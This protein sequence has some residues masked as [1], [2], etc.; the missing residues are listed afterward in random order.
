MT[1]RAF[2]A[3]AVAATLRL[4]LPPHPPARATLAGA[5]SPAT[6]RWAVARAE[7]APGMI[8][9]PTGFE[10]A[11]R[12][13]YPEQSPE[14]RAVL[15]LRQLK[16][17]GRLP[18]RLVVMVWSGAEGHWTRPFP[19]GAPSVQQLLEQETGVRLEIEPV[20]Y[21]QSLTRALQDTLNGERH[22]DIYAFSL[23]AIGTLVESGALLNLDP[24]VDRYKPEWENQKLG[25]VE[26]AHLAGR[27][28]KYRG[29]YYA[30]CFDGDC[31]MPVYRKDLFEDE[32]E[33]REFRARYGWDLRPPDTWEQFDQICEFFHRPERGLIGCTDLRNPGWGFTN[34]VNRYACAADPYQPYFDPLT[35]Q[36]LIASPAGIQAT[37]E[38]VSS[39]RWHPP[40]A[41]TWGWPE[42][43][44]NMARGGAAMT[45]AFP[46]LPRFLDNPQGPWGG[47]MVGKLGSFIMPGRV[48]N[49]K[50]VR[51][52][53]I[54][55]N[56]MHGVASGSRAPEAAYLVLQWAGG[57]RLHPWIA[58]N[59]A[60]VYDLFQVPD[61]EAPISAR[62]F[63]EWH[64]WP[65]WDSVA[66]AVPPITLPGF[67]EYME[68]GALDANL[69]AALLGRKTPE[70]A[71][72]DCAAEWEQITERLGRDKQIAALAPAMRYWPTIVDPPVV[73]SI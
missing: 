33:V 55:P 4:A 69:E 44:A 30:V 32:A 1:R 9:G 27:L 49:G 56:A 40:E 65:Y 72:L 11:E 63:K 39:M 68:G 42:Q 61:Y 64:V 23:S 47:D 53:I 58:A 10:G 67:A 24:L 60:G 5:G 73:P 2:V 37:Q 50:L 7:L 43:F 57:G 22:F 59:P 19:K 18:E 34:W 25:Y 38:I 15:A 21:A 54:W 31:H 71:M 29:A 70:Q 66:R 8:G 17:E 51:R 14:G 45:I 28:N 62:V 46:N 12:H 36:P 13:Q 41:R 6:P 35:A 52:P 26:G 16:A 20:P 3:G 48:I